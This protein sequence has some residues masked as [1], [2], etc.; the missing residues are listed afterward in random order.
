MHS[1]SPSESFSSLPHRCVTI[2]N[3]S[4]RHRNALQS[5]I[6][7]SSLPS[8]RVLVRSCL[9]SAASGKLDH[10]KYRG[11]SPRSSDRSALRDVALK[12][13]HFFTVDVL[14]GQAGQK[15]REPSR[16]HI[17]DG[18]PTTRQ[19]SSINVEVTLKRAVGWPVF[20]AVRL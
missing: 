8:S 13:R 7:F 11:D 18:G 16:E 3:F 20:F 2:L 12:G 4:P 1:R 14:S 9:R 10:S 5:K 17:S 15:S 19:R 6:L